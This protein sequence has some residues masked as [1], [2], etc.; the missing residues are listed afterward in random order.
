M[1]EKITEKRVKEMYGKVIRIAYCNLQTLLRYEEPKYYT[2]GVYGWN[3]DIYQVD[4]D[5]AIVTGYRPFGNVKV[6]YKIQREFEE[7]A[8]KIISKFPFGNEK[9]RKEIKELLLKFVNETIKE[10]NK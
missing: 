1:K 2:A 6:D 4:S 9:A 8:M 3:A 10:E 5:V 7:K